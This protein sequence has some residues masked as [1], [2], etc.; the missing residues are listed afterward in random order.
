M[1]KKTLRNGSK[2][3]RVVKEWMKEDQLIDSI[4]PMVDERAEMDSGL[5][6]QGQGRSGWRQ[7]ILYTYLH[8]Y[9]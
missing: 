7:S 4:H 8:M 1:R 2:T 9:V 3:K 6:C 5:T